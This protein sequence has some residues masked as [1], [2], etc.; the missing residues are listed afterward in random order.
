MMGYVQRN[1]AILAGFGASFTGVAFL[2]TFDEVVELAEEWL[3]AGRSQYDEG[4]YH[5]AFEALRNAAELA[6][7]ALL[8]R[9]TGA[10]VQDHS[11]AGPLAK[12]GAIPPKVDGRDLHK[13]LSRFTL[14]PYGF[15]VTI[16]EKDVASALRLADRMVK[17]CRT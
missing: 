7:K 1:A 16:H 15:D 6:A 10:F 12:A 11:V 13:L 5:V 4:R 14:G 2:P 9:A 17:A 3:D 8:L